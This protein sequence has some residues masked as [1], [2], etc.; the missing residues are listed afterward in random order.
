MRGLFVN[1]A[2]HVLIVDVTIPRCSFVFSQSYVQV[3]ASLTDISSLA[4][5]SIDLVN[6]SL[7][8]LWVVFVLNV[9]QWLSKS[10]DGSVSKLN[11]G[12]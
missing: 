4:S 7:S 10:S 2:Q 12:T 1:G 11:P 6:C 8:V 9:R 5:R 3:S